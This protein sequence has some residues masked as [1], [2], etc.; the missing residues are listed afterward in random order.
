MNRV[1]DGWESEENVGND[2][3]GERGG[4]LTCNSGTINIDKNIVWPT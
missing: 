1:Q 4:E 3:L 2:E